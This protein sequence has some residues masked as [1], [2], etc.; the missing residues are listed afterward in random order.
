VAGADVA[1]LAAVPGIG[2]ALAEQIH[3][4]FHP[5]DTAGEAPLL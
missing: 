1:T 3:A 4:A 2:R 5:G